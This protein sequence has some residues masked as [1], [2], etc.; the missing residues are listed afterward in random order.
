M[1][2]NELSK[3]LSENVASV[4]AHLLPQGKKSGGEWCAGSISGEPGQSLKVR[5]TGMK[6][7]VWSDFATSA[8]GDMLDLWMQCRAQ[9]IAEAMREAKQLL[10]VRDDMPHRE[11]PSYKRPAK[12]KRQAPQSVLGDWF[13]TRGIATATLEA[14]RI[15]EQERN[16]TVYAVFPYIRDGELINAKYRNIAEKKDMRQEAGAEP[17]LFGW[18]LIDPK[19]RGI[20][21]TEGEIDAMSLYQVGIPALSVNAGAGNHQWIDNDW[22][23]LERFSEIYLCYDND[24]AGQKGAKEVANRLGLDRCKVV[25]FPTKDANDFLLTGATQDDFK[26]HFA[27]ARNFDPDE[28]RS[29]ADYWAEMKALFYPAQD[30]PAYPQLSFCGEKQ[31]WFEFRPGELTVWT[32]YN[33]HGKSLMLNQIMV[34][35]MDQ[36][37]RMCVFSGEMTPARQCKRMAKQLGGVDR[38]APQYLDAME[39]WIRGR[40]WL[41]DLVGTASID[42]LLTVF[43]YAFK[44]YGIRHFVIDSLMMTDV[45]EDGAGAMTSQ[46]DAMRKLAAFSRGNNV[47]VHLVAHPRKGR[48][49]SDAPGKMDIAGSGKI[50]D[51]ADNVFSVWSAQKEEGQQDDKPDAM[52]E[53]FKNRNGEV[54]HRKLYLYFN[55]SCM[56]FSTHRSRR[57]HVHVPFTAKIGEAA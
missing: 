55:K 15:G 21:I 40:A 11:S 54:Q 42:R 13:A 19:K 30:Q 48:D 39:T 16:G 53:L 3:L 27:Q 26:K 4:A 56:Q 49:E 52:L 28:L 23:R 41:F 33:G 38:P 6:R 18:H 46:K 14:F 7:G 47:H 25:T 22:S 2:A 35:I 12:L 36:G 45:L 50:T 32:G 29:M 51:A 8:S 44:R 17:C 24:E 37:E 57:P 9:S 5:L 31:D 34:G 43:G 10:G 1:N 20:A